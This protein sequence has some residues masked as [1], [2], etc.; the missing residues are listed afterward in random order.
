MVPLT[1][2]VDP[3]ILA[4]TVSPLLAAAVNVVLFHRKICYFGG[5]VYDVKVC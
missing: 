1:S 5:D 4:D 3:T 2:C